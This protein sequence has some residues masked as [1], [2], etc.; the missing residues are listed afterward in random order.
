M[1]I[2]V[3]NEPNPILLACPQGIPIYDKV[4]VFAKN[5]IEPKSR[6]MIKLTNDDMVWVGKSENQEFQQYVGYIED[7]KIQIHPVL[8][9][10]T[11]VQ[12]I[13]KQNI[14]YQSKNTALEQGL[15]LFQQQ[16]QTAQELGTSKSRRK[17]K[18]METNKIQEENIAEAEAIKEIFDQK[19]QT[20]KDEIEIQKFEHEAEEQQLKVDLLPEFDDE[21]LIDSIIYPED[22]ENLDINKLQVYMTDKNEDHLKYYN[23]YIIQLLKTLGDQDIGQQK[24]KGFNQKSIHLVKLK[25]IEYLEILLKFQNKH[26]FT[27]GVQEISHE[28]HIRNTDI[29]KRILNKFYQVTND[30]QLQFNRSKFLQDKY[31]CYVIVLHLFIYNFKFNA[32][33]L[34]KQLRLNIKKMTEYCK[35]CRCSVKSVENQL[36]VRFPAK[37]SDK[38]K[39]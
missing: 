16:K 24:Q 37:S 27:K 39:K 7:N 20:L 5:I 1:I 13:E 2:E 34:A 18:Q 36:S 29:V 8:F 30:K 17:M 26:T 35:M 23:P 25:Y 21:Y 31:F 33:E 15:T 32:N 28:L 6:K 4:Q 38:K 10:G 19:K 11:L 3:N 14:D 12:S 9:S 22:M